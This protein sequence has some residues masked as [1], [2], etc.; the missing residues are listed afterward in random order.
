MGFWHTGYAE[1]HELSGLENYVYSPPPPVQYIC[2]H[3]AASFA[4]IEALRRHRFEQHPVR[5][6]ALWLR[7]RAAGVLPQLLT[8][9]L[10]AKDVVVEDASR[11]LLNGK[12]V[13]IADLASTL[14]AMT[15]EFVKLQLDNDGASTCCVLDF[16]IA[17][18]AHLIGVEAA[19]LRLARDKILSIDSIARFIEDCRAFHSAMSYCDGICHYLYGVM[20]KEN[21]PGSGL[22]Q[23]E[24]VGRYMRASDELS[25]FDRALARSVRSVIAFHF[26]QFDEA[27]LLAPEG[28][29]R[30]AA[31][32]FAGLLQGLSWH[33]DDAFSPAVGGAVEDLLTDQDTLQIL[34]DASHGLVELK[35]KADD[36]VA[37]MRRAP[38]GG[39]DQLK[40]TLLAS[41]ALAA[42]ADAISHAEARKL[43]R[44]LASKHDTSA[45]AEA[46]L[47]KLPK[48]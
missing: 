31:H 2:E 9:R 35:A 17:D 3:C 41:E 26:N 44:K 39:Y 32:T 11:C 23:G 38:A 1:F 43:A 13:L 36:L 48:T 47:E 4:G 45:W 8:T 18:E 42:R 14:A 20:A 12:P 46:M 6:P 25:G 40:R 33:F 7:G 22:R 16:R 34:A 37:H 28:A 15:R 10:S 24:Y 30:H 21:S 29:L 27:K 19:F 5:Q